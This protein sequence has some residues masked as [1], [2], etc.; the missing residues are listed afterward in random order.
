MSDQ[1]RRPGEIE[2]D[3]PAVG[4]HDGML[5]GRLLDPGARQE[6]GRLELEP[7]SSPAEPG[8]G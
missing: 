1:H 8:T 4:E 3:G 2:V 6:L 5:T 7:G